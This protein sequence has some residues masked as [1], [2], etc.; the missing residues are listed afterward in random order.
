MIDGKSIIDCRLVRQCCL[1]VFKIAYWVQLLFSFSTKG[2]QKRMPT[3]LPRDIDMHWQWKLTSC[4]RF[5]SSY[6]HINLHLDVP[7]D[8][9]IINQLIHLF[10]S[11][12]TVII[13]MKIN[14]AKLVEMSNEGLF[15]SN[16]YLYVISDPDLII[17]EGVIAEITN[18]YR[19]LY[20]ATK[21][22]FT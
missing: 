18:V 5:L 11:E 19:F 12:S 7:L 16:F 22:F 2:L 17:S 8:T 10:Y 15:W 13:G 3:S 21:L 1:L 6:E 9:P 20:F 14:L 4:W